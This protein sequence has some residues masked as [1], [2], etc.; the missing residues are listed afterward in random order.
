MLLGLMMN[1][2]NERWILMFFSISVTEWIYLMDGGNL[3]DQIEAKINKGTKLK[4][5]K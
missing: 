1:M 3:K 4:I 2:M 5:S